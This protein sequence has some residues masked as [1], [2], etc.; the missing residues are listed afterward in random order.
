MS[1]RDLQVAKQFM[2]KELTS[3]QDELFCQLFKDISGFSQSISDRVFGQQDRRISIYGVRGIGKT[4]AMQGALWNGL[5]EK[6]TDKYVPINVVVM[7]ARGVRDPMQLSD[8]F[9]KSV[10][11]GVNRVAKASGLKKD[12]AAAAA[13]YAPWV[14]RKITETAGVV[15]G[16][17]A[18]ASDLSEN[19]VKWLVKHLGYSNIDAL[20]GSKDLDS[21][22]AATLLIDKLEDEGGKL[23]FMIDELDKVE[24]DTVLSDF[25][26]GNQAWFQGKQGMISLSYTFG[27]SL[28]KTLVTSASRI[29]L[30]EGFPGI[31]SSEDAAEIIRS[32]AELGLSQIKES[33]EAAAAAAIKMIPDETIRAILNVSAPNS[34]IMLERASQA[35][36]SA[37]SSKSVIVFPDHVYAEP[38]EQTIPTGLET[39]FLRELTACRLSPSVIS[40]RLH[41]DRGL[42]TRT[43]KKLM[44]KDWVGRIG[45]GKR[46]Y[47]FITAKGEAANR[48]IKDS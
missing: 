6:R 18:L 10:I 22:Q 17:I 4:T 36:D 32:R 9:F 2:V 37:L 33:E 26:D 27:E 11:L 7:G 13:R 48:R 43:L 21:Q 42:T 34:H 8:L 5:R 12:L 41:K 35:I 1:E 20:L 44:M 38:V 15:I 46:A 29:S 30:I 24:N 19:G 3:Y 47:Y 16:P 40:D 25:F 28:S 39:S 14:A 45:E 31:T 23:V